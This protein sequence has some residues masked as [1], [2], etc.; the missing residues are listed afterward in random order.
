MASAPL[1]ESAPTEEQLCDA[2]LAGDAHAWSLLVRKHNHRVVV[3][4]LA[5]GVPADRTHDL[6]QDVWLRLLEQQRK[7]RLRA[8]VL[9]GLALRQARFLA[10]E[11]RRSGAPRKCDEE[12]ESLALPDPEPDAEERLLGHEKLARARRTLAQ[13]NPTARKVFTA[14]YDD[15]SRPQAEIAEEVGLSLQRV[16]QLLC[17]VRNK[18]RAALRGDDDV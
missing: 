9:P 2:A 7:G 16:R 12:P 14:V 17:E 6:A 3:A 1:P 11:L 8:L 15:P 5:W 18:L 4:L 13:C 10:L